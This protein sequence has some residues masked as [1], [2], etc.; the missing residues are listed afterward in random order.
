MTVKILSY[1]GPSEFLLLQ[2]TV[3][4]GTFDREKIQTIS[5]VAEDKYPLGV[6]L[7]PAT[8]VWHAIMKNGFNGAGNNRWFRLTGSDRNGNIIDRQTINFSVSTA[9]SP[10]QSS[11]ILTVLTDALFQEV[12]ADPLSLTPQQTVAVPA[13]QIYRINK[14]DVVDDY[15][16]V[17]LGK[18]V[19]PIGKF[20]YFQTAQV[21]LTKG[22][23]I[24]RF[25][26]ANL[27]STPPDMQLL[28]VRQ[29]TKIK[30][31][32]EDNLLLRPNEQG[33]L[34]PGEIYMIR[35]YAS[36]D[37]HFRVSLNEP[38]FGFGDTGYIESERVEVRDRGLAVG[39]DSSALTLRV[40]KDTVLKKMPIDESFLKPGEQVMLPGGMVY[41]VNSYAYEDGHLKVAIAENFPDF[42]NRGYLYP[43]FVQ[44]IS[45]NQS[46]DTPNK[47]TYEGPIEVLVQQPVV[48]RGRYN[49][50]TTTIVT[51]IAE[52]KFPL[53]VD[54]DRN[55][56]TWESNLTNG[57]YLSG[58][59]WMRLR[60][61][62]NQGN[63]VE[64]QVININVSVD[65]L[66]AGEELKLTVKT[67][68]MFKVATLDVSSLNEQQKFYIKAD[69]T[70]TVQKYGLVG[71]H[72][73]V[74][75]DEAIAP[76]GNFGYFYE[77][78]VE[79]RKGP[80]RLLFDFTDVPDTNTS[81]KMLVIQKTFIKGSTEMSS[82]LPN[83]MKAELLPGKN[84]GISGYA[85]TRGHFRVT[86]TE[87]VPGFGN[88]GYVYSRHVR[89][90]KF[91]EEIL[92]NPNAITAT[93]REE[94]V[95]KKRPVNASQLSASDKVTL[96]LGR[97]YGVNSYAIEDGHVK[98][99][100]TEEF[101]GFGNTGYLFPDYVLFQRGGKTFDPIPDVVEMN[102]PYFS[103]WNNP[104]FYWSTCNVTAIAMVFHYYG[105]RSQWRETLADELLE[106]TI[107]NYGQG[108]QTI[109]SVLSALI[110]AYG[111]ETSFSTTR[112]WSDLKAEL[113]NRRPLVLA[114][115]FTASGHI[116]TVIGYTPEGYIVHDPWGNALTGYY[117]TEGGW[118]IYPYS[119]INRV[120]GPDGNVWAHFTRPK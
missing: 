59:R 15:L 19:P 106:W 12:A 68:T 10:S 119:Y 17:E 108:S 70:F 69:S 73:K 94:T 107:Q 47:L 118:L 80:K 1:L 115:D 98:V 6:T 56:A 3:I 2:P 33:E 72:L 36:I 4:T 44:I 34:D 95:F 99:A 9:T 22:A 120:C 18:I 37:N 110:R 114:G 86:L 74:L 21:Q 30:V 39:F 112:R 26:A 20:G 83:N 38:I 48:L 52:D 41:G 113:I 116:I 82:R 76:F 25:D 103:Q 49:P 16:Q 75:L 31:K 43:D 100:M 13:G 40:L 91:D 111:F 29:R 55:S 92:Y 62:D 64:S 53:R 61:L 28:W 14:Y 90:K 42:G 23:K 101:P 24:L 32:P 57:I 51:L 102:I 89:I 88:V 60:A 78:D 81:A 77:P 63:T 67:G 109:H 71:A 96:P 85:S 58:P 105:I 5:L 65:N 35:G 50:G 93:I 54:I 79:L 27:P 97:V 46:F 7:N 87:S 84:F 11:L 45:A 117:D 8:G 66:T 104:R